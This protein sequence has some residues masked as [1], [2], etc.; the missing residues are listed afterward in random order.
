M[1][2]RKGPKAGDSA[3]TLS[4]WSRDNLCR[5]EVEEDRHFRWL[6]SDL[7]WRV[8]PGHLGWRQEDLLGGCC[9]SKGAMIQAWTQIFWRGSFVAGRVLLGTE[10]RGWMCVVSESHRLFPIVH[11]G[12]Q[13]FAHK[14]LHTLWLGSLG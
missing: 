7:R 13:G 2:G 8:G 9:I 10:R 5:G 6:T 1:Q 11:A 4:P 12:L 3:G 14:A